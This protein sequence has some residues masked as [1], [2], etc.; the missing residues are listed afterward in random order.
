MKHTNLIGVDVSESS[1]KILE[2]SS[3]YEI[4]AYGSA[5]LKEGIVTGGFIVDKE[6]F[7]KTL[8]D[9][10]KNT[11]PRALLTEHN[12]LR[13]VLSLPE[14][15]LFTHFVPIPNTV[16]KSDIPEYIRLDAE[17]VIPF[18]LSEMYWDFHLVENANMHYAIFVGAPKRNIN[19][20]VEA[21]S[22][23]DIKPALI[24]GELFSLGR[25]LLSDSASNEAVIILDIGSHSTT[26]GIFH[27]DS[28]AH[29]SVTVPLAGDDFTKAIAG[30]LSITVPEAESLKRDIGLKSSDKKSEVPK[31]LTECIDK[32]SYEVIEARAHFET[33]HKVS[34]NRIIVAGGSA[35]IPGLTQLLS[36]KVGL[37]TIIANPFTKIQKNALFESGTPAIFFANVVGLGLLATDAHLKGLNL[38]TQYRYS[39]GG[40]EKERL[41][42]RDVR[43][44]ADAYYFVYGCLHVGLQLLSRLNAIVMPLFGK[45]NV[46]L[47]TSIILVIATL[48]FLV[49]VIRLYT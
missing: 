1:I 4:T 31:I 33:I 3:E 47:I 25:A 34:V 39:D 26:I 18:R 8:K 19:N 24:G 44:A 15:K 17:K 23:A 42:I 12:T 46:K 13:A 43:S 38:L 10:L 6:A 37:E 20:Y 22:E 5:P 21:F 14:S 49:W 7:A 45:M 32:I 11:K 40:A 29:M 16:K 30:K 41:S 36:E 27:V 35:L 9:I 28:I 2:L 48:T